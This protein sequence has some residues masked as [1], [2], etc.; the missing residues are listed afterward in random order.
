MLC[1]GLQRV[2]A[3]YQQPAGLSAGGG[4]GIVGLVSIFPNEHLERLRNPAWARIA[5]LLGGYRNR[6]MLDLIM[7]CG[8]FVPLA[9]KEGNYYQLSGKFRHAAAL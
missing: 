2:Q 8:L 1:H 9:G 7:E 6:L 3:S 5:S 4:C